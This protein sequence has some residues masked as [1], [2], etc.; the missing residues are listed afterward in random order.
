M[1][2]SES[3]VRA[4]REPY[5]QE[6]G[7]AVLLRARG[8][9]KAFG[10]QVVV[11][12]GGGSLELNRGE[13][14]LLRGLNG[15]GKTTLLNILTGNL[16]PDSGAIDLFTRARRTFF[17]FPRPWLKNLTPSS[18]TPQFLSRSGIGRTWQEARLFSTQSLR[19]NIAVATPD[20]LGENPHKPLTRPVA[21]K[22]QE[23]GVRTTSDD[24]LSRLGLRG[25]EISSCDKISLGQSKRV[26][27]A[28]SVQA[29][30]Q[31][32]FLDEPLA[33][34]DDSGIAD[35][36]ALLEQLVREQQLTLVIVEHV[37]NVQRILDL[38]TTVWTL[39][40]GQVK[41][42]TPSAVRTEISRLKRNGIQ[43]W[44]LDIAGPD[45][46]IQRQDLVG[47][48]TLTT[49]T[50]ATAIPGDVVLD[51]KDISVKRGNRLVIGVESGAGLIEGVS[52]ALSRGQIGVLE[53][54]NGWGK[55]T[56]LEAIAGTLPIGQGEI[57]FQLGPIEQLSSWDRARLGISLLQARGNTF[58]NLTVRE[59][60]ELARIGRPPERFGRLM[61]KKMSDLSGGEKQSVSLVCA[62]AA[63]G[64][65]LGLLDEPFAS[66]DIDAVQRSASSLL[67]RLKETTLLIATPATLGWEAGSRRLQQ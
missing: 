4:A 48:A 11:N 2:I 55:T 49:L 61:N 54:P 32:L 6:S 46:S 65:E 1:S 5:P 23:A 7:G 35:V 20:Q 36:I 44:M 50:P 53:A 63:K 40:K 60:F 37:F 34:L 25:R 27:I 51:V 29:G 9:R 56:L 38:A 66:L 31:I 14:V 62:I 64:F 58:S 18:F 26:A 43:E 13:V 45:C 42:E 24:I 12:M 30:A 10:A 41:V 8:L 39:E 52:F 3:K 33:G 28:S 59:V 21:V 17:T 15:S 67:E 16:D 19:N 47:G 57:R 22:R